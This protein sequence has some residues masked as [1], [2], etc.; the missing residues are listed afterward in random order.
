MSDPEMINAMVE[1]ADPAMFSG[2]MT[3][4]TKPEVMESM[5]ESMNPQIMMEMMRMMPAMMQAFSESQGQ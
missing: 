1:M 2:L 5:M 3:T 4:M